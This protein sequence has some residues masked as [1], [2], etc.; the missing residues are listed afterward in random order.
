[1]V[2]G[3]GTSV[4]ADGVLEGSIL[5]HD[6]R[7]SPGWAGV[8]STFAT[9]GGALRLASAGIFAMSLAG[10][11][12][13]AMAV[14]FGLDR[15]VNGFQNLNGGVLVGATAM[16]A[17]TGV[18]LVQV[19]LHGTQL[20]VVGGPSGGGGRTISGPHTTSGFDGSVFHSPLPGAA[21]MKELCG[22]G[23][24]TVGAGAYGIGSTL[25]TTGGAHWHAH[26]PFVLVGTAVRVGVN[27]TAGFTFE[28]GA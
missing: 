16:D 8:T 12:A 7:Q 11:F 15:Q 10:V 26:S 21:A 1:M 19:G 24:S 6:S 18:I 28:P 2:G 20:P 22:A 23:T 27:G 25:V 9:T 3:A 17:G 5:P 13:P 4:L 14:S